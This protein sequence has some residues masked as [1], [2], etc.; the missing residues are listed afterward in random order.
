M[1]AA[2][3]N[4]GRKVRPHLRLEE[5][6]SAA[7]Q[8]GTPIGVSSVNIEKVIQGMWLAANREGTAR[9]ARVEGFEVCGKT[10]STQVVSRQTAEKL[11]ETRRETRTHSWFTG[12]AP[13][14]DAQVVVTI[15]V[16]FGGMGGSTAAPLARELFSLYRELTYHD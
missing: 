7:V 8:G 6:E 4:R 3:A 2:L 16:E 15:I 11:G 5:G 10:G 14:N 13:R 12:F 1:T 9:A